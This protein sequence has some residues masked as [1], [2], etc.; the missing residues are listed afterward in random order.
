MYIYI[1][2]QLPIPVLLFASLQ[3]DIYRKPMRG[4]WDELIQEYND[5]EVDLKN[6]F[7]VGD[8]AGRSA[9]WKPNMKKDHSCVDRKFACN[10]GIDFFTPEAYFTNEKEADFSWGSVNIKDYPKPSPESSTKLTSLV[11]NNDNSSK[12]EL[13]LLVGPP[14]SGKSSF[15][16]NYLLSKDYVYINQDTLKTKAKCINACEKALAE[17]KSVV[18]DNTNSTIETRSQFIKIAKKHKIPIR[19]FK[20]TT[21]IELC[22]HNNY[23]RSIYKKDRPLLSEIVFRV[24]SSQYQPPTLKEGFSDI[25]SIDFHFPGNDHDFKEWQNWYI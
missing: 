25:Q 4:M 13:I 21:D 3:K 8:A 19:C 22:K 16:Q 15:A 23:Y 9:G 24:F 12:V 20:F 2:I 10:V 1:Y 14:A 11:S 6:S 7:Y 17:K 18:I 5:T